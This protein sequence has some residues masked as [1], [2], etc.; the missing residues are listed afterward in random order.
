[1]SRA[2]MYAADVVA[3]AILVSPS[4]SRA[5]GAATFAALALDLIGGLSASP[6]PL[7]LDRAVTDPARLPCVHAAVVVQR[8]RRQLR[9]RAPA[10]A[11]AAREGRRIAEVEI[12]SVYREANA[13]SHFRPLAGL[14]A[15]LPAAAG[16]HPLVLARLRGRRG[17]AA[18]T[19]RNH[20]G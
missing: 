17:R 2:V 19:R 20:G 15:N 12:E 10:A 8:G 5:T 18:R 11:A 4:S 1:M 16:L 3:V 7:L 6:T 14:G 13:S 9:V